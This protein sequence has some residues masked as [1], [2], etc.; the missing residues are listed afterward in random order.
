MYVS[1][2][3]A[4]ACDASGHPSQAASCLEHENEHNIDAGNVCNAPDGVGALLRAL[5]GSRIGLVL[6][7]FQQLRP[8]GRGVAS[9]VKCLLEGAEKL[10]NKTCAESR[11]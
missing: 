11:P 6:F 3:E 1:V 4:H 10:H 5:L 7:L 9:D 2:T 8:H